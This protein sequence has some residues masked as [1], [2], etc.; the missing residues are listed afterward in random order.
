MMSGRPRITV[1]G[2]GP[3]GPGD[4]TAATLELLQSENQVFVRTV[5]HPTVKLLT[6]VVSFDHL[7]EEADTFDEVYDRIV[8]ELVGHAHDIGS[9]VYAVPGSPLVLE[10]S[11]QRLRERA[12]GQPE[13]RSAGTE[14]FDSSPDPGV[15]VGI[16][17]A[18]SF[19][20]V[21]W[22]TLGVDPVDDGV[23]LV[24]GHRF[25]SHG[26]GQAGPMLV[27]HVHADWVLSSIKLSVEE[28]P[29]QPVVVLQR[30]GTADEHV[31][32]VSWHDLDRV[33]PD[34][35]TTLYIPE[36][37]TPPGQD[38]ALS[39]ELMHRLRHE[40]PWDQRQDHATLR[41]YLRE[42][43]YEVLDALDRVVDASPEGIN[44]AYEDLESELGDL[45]FQILFHC[46]LAA[47]QG[48]F[49]V[50]DVARTLTTKM[51][52]RHPH[53]FDPE[54]NFDGKTLPPRP[55]D[56]AGDG[57]STDLGDESAMAKAW[58]AKKVEQSSRRSIFDGIPPDL[59]SLALA[60]KV[61]GK[62]I[63]AFGP[64]EPGPAAG[65]LVGL[66]GS[67]PGDDGGSDLDDM[68]EFYGRT[69]LALA[70]Q[71]RSVGIDLEHVLRQA[72]AD[73]VAVVGQLET[74]DSGPSGVGNRE[75]ESARW[76][77]G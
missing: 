64:P 17:P 12:S 34:H 38:L 67:P 28:P 76:V 11:V 9:V 69:L 43:A 40:C 30:L 37:A 59:P 8:D 70:Q 47:E 15:D 44:L 45:W 60:D 13:G 54:V 35:L 31:A 1:C 48:Q 77:L 29:E 62:A 50:A 36:L 57:V 2:L 14:Q 58:E 65:R 52:E 68:G 24:D 22:S 61:L 75:A 23:R 55:S 41:K 27:A 33:D 25:A 66:L 19:L 10:R 56:A 5:K 6:N 7:Y 72:V 39:I 26:A 20:D 63:R 73:L 51:V 42:E 46:R 53:V 4:V 21:A 32:E 71:A 74:A 16:M 3:G 18:M 49:T